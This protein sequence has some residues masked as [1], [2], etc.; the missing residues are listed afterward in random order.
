MEAQ[1]RILIVD[2]ENE[3]LNTYRN[4]FVKRGFSVDVAHD[5][6]EG[7]EKLRTRQFD[8]A[9]V[10]LKMPRSNGLEMIRQANTE[11]IDT[12]MIILTGHGEKEDAI[13]TI[14]LGY[15]VVGA[16]F[17][18]SGIEMENLLAKVKQLLEGIPLEEVQRILA[19]IPEEGL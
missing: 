11:S 14:N 3:I 15:S 4:F 1:D 19:V 18:K 2:D 5:G 10:D 16:W 6:I 13:A 8:V 9:I 7:L 17:E 12:E